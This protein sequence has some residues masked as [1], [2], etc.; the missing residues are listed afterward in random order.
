[1]KNSRMFLEVFRD[2]SAKTTGEYFDCERNRLTAIIDDL[3][4]MP[5]AEWERRHL[6]TLMRIAREVDEAHRPLEGAE[7]A[8]CGHR[9]VRPVRGRR[10]DGGGRM[11]RRLISAIAR[12]F[13]RYKK[14][15]AKP[16]ETSAPVLAR[17]VVPIDICECVHCP[18]GRHTTL[19]CHN[20][21]EAYVREMGS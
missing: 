12:R 15:T 13:A 18:L 10:C 4:R 7:L 6:P 3:A 21:L 9:G 11:I 8:P 17:I 5:H 20:D 14:H 19:L 16:E 2:L 1:M